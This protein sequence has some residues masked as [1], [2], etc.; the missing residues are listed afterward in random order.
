MGSKDL[1]KQKGTAARGC[2]ASFLNKDRVNKFR[3]R[4]R[5]KSLQSS[6]QKVEIAMPAVSQSHNKKS[7][8]FCGQSIEKKK[9]EPRFRDARDDW[10]VLESKES[11]FTELLILRVHKIKPCAIPPPPSLP[12]DPL[13][14]PFRTASRLS[15][16]AWLPKPR[17]PHPSFLASASVSVLNL[18]ACASHQT[19]NK[20]QTT[21]T[22]TYRT[23][24]PT[25]F[26]LPFPARKTV[27][28]GAM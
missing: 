14:A 6:N 19:H 1:R 5:L 21:Q 12:S 25:S 18:H 7:I 9:N 2:I 4:S 22:G 27:I 10:G 3:K 13:Y 15:P 20:T 16:F 23:T 8:F 11:R 26:L 28:A 24:G 17:P